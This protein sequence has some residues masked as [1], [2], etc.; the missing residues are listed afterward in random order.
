MISRREFVR[1]GALVGA[2]MMLPIG[3]AEKA[4]AFNVLGQTLP[5]NPKL[6]TKYVDRLPVMSAIDA[7]AGGMFEIQ[8]VPNAVALSSSMAAA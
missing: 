6:L 2:G 7:T 3:L 4:F 5:L 1:I 8:A